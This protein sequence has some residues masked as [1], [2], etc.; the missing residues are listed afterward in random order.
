MGITKLS[1]TG[2]I[3]PDE[4]EPVRNFVLTNEF[5]QNSLDMLIG[6]TQLQSYAPTFSSISGTTAPNIGD[7][8]T[9]TGVWIPV[10]GMIYGYVLIHWSGSGIDPGSGNNYFII[11]LPVAVHPDLVEFIHSGSSWSSRSPA[12]GSAF[13]RDNSSL[14]VNS[15]TATVQLYDNLNVALITERG[16]SH[17]PV[18]HDDPFT[19]ADGD[20]I[21]CS[22]RYRGVD[23]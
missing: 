14:S 2:L 5:N 6:S 15:Q 4:N 8:G 13:L 9:V 16:N 22:F 21:S 11:S 7:T 20:R 18:V 10:F 23:V 3:V 17:R 1:P 12:V 19:W